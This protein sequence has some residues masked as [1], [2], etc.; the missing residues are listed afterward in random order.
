VKRHTLILPVL[1]AGVLMG[2][3][4]IA[5]VGPALP[6]IAETFGVDG[7]ALAWVF[8]SYVLCYLVGAP[9]IAKLSDRHGRRT[10]YIGS[11][12]I[13]AAG[14]LAIAAAPA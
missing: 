3:L 2:A 1:F 7:R 9:L 12:L 4:D 8:N 11:L 14:S 13:F 6:A 10:V 5:I